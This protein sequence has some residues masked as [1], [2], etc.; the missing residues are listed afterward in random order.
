V[1]NKKKSDYLVD[2]QIGF[3]LRLAVQFH[4]GIFTSLMIENLTQTQF[5][6]LARI[7]EVGTCTQS[8]LTRLLALDSATV[9]GVIERLHNR[10]LLHIADDPSDGRRQTISLTE[11]GLRIYEL[12]ELVAREI[13]LKTVQA[14]TLSEQRR[15]IYLLNKMIGT[16]TLT[17]DKKINPPKRRIRSAEKHYRKLRR[18]KR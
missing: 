4:T 14:L 18:A 11:Q 8:D 12:A 13:T 3:V 5:A 6:T 7:R 16:P 1:V 9:N 2:Q 17:L 15:L 10:N